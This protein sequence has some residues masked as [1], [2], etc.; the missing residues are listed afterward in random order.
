M[1]FE[2]SLLRP[3]SSTGPRTFLFE[4]RARLERGP[5]A[6]ACLASH[7]GVIKDLF[8]LTVTRQG[9]EGKGKDGSNVM[10]RKKGAITRSNWN[11][12]GQAKDGDE[13]LLFTNLVKPHD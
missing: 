1:S 8:R 9:K 11:W 3:F 13:L 12:N 6:L 2:S 7:L 10:E 5:H 4:R